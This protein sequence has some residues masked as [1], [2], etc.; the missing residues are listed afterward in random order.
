MKIDKKLLKLSL[1]LLSQCSG[2]PDVTTYISNQP[3]QGFDF[4]Y[5]NGSK[6][7]FVPYSDP[8]TDKLVC[9]TVDDIQAMLAYAK[10]S[11]PQATVR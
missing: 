9:F 2:G 5:S 7:G 1:I 8:T 6:H 10:A 4:S 3:A 11:C